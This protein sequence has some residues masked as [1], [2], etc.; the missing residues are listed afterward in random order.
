MRVSRFPAGDLAP[1]HIV[2]ALSFD[3]EDYFH[4][5]ALERAFGGAAWDAL[6]SR[7][8]DNT[9]RLLHLLDETGV[10]ATFF[11]LGWVA[12]RFPGLVRDIHSRA[13]EV[14]CH[15]YSHHLVY[16]QLP[17]EFRQETLRAKGL[18]EDAIGG[19]VSGYRAAS[20]SITG[21]SIWAL[22]ILREAGFEYDSS[23]FPIHHDRY[24]VPG[25]SR[26]IH[27]IDCGDAGELVEF[28]PST[29]RVGRL[30]LPVGGG[31][32]FRLLPFW[33]TRFGLR[34]LNQKEGQP[35]MFYL[36]PWEVDTEQPVG[37]VGW[38]TRVRHYRNIHR[39]AERLRML[40][41]DGSF[42]PVRDILRN[43]SETGQSV[44]YGEA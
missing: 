6:P 4:A 3:I 23:I 19:P 21:E 10:K 37:K 38:L 41:A 25:A 13:H 32:Y 26:F 33:Y 22:R 44:R 2:N 35:L 31:G 27:R 36:H 1:G 20:F 34:H 39:C 29:V 18:L 8:E 17:E 5:A 40:I 11:I 15:G 42:A 16:R 24:G 14:A 7:V 30:T 43:R 9:R 28:P 12:E